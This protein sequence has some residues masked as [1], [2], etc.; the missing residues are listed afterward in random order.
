MIQN[1]DYLRTIPVK[2][3]S[4]WLSNFRNDLLMIACLNKIYNRIRQKYK[5][6]N[7]KSWDIF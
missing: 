3:D 7:N 4:S 5:L 1:G 6:N 2:F